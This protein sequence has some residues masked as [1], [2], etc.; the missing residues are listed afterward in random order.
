[1]ECCRGSY[2]DMATFHGSGQIDGRPSIPRRL[3]EAGCRISHL[4]SKEFML[5]HVIPAFPYHDATSLKN[6]KQPPRRHHRSTRLSFLCL[7][8]HDMSAAAKFASSPS[9]CCS[10]TA[11]IY[12]FPG[13][14]DREEAFFCMAPFGPKL[15]GVSRIAARSTNQPP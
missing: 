14:E 15:H 1:M 10:S 8:D 4:K 7:S 6:R 12:P 3:L 2:Q 5:R 9:T 11:S 13:D